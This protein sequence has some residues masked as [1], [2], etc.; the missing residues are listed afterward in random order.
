M[1]NHQRLSEIPSAWHG[2][3]H[4]A[5]WIVET[6][7]P[8]V[9]VDLG[10]DHGFS[11]LVLAQPGFGTVYGIDANAH[12]LGYAKNMAAELGIRNIEFINSN[13]ATVAAAWAKP[14]DILHIDGD[15]G[16]CDV[17]S[18]FNTWVPHLRPGGVL[19][20]HDIDAF[21]DGPGRVFEET[22]WPKWCIHQY[23]GLGVLTKPY[24]R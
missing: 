24:D 8:H 21:K 14:V 18:D 3:E 1:K 13:F 15:H 16:Y 7:R 12:T 6:T 20:M 4:I 23:H 17:R 9:T 11:T 19:L 2:L 5:D 10:V 22:N